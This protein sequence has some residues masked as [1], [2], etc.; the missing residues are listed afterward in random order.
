VVERYFAANVAHLC[1]EVLAM[2]R[3][4]LAA[5]EAAK[6]EEEW[7]RRLA[8]VVRQRPGKLQVRFL[9]NVGRIE[10]SLQAAVHAELHHTAKPF[11]VPRE[12]ITHGL[13]ISLPGTAKQLRSLSGIVPHDQ[14][15]KIIIARTALFYTELFFIL[16]RGA[17]AVWVTDFLCMVLASLVAVIT[18]RR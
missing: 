14:S 15:H 11:A 17:M 18:L 9:K 8:Q 7:H 16:S 1:P 13:Q 2:Q 12:E 6:P 3:V 10:A 4:Q 5:G